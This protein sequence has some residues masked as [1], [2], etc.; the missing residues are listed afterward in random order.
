MGYSCL[1]LIFTIEGCLTEIS[2]KMKHGPKGMDLLNTLWHGC[3]GLMIAEDP[4]IAWGLIF[5]YS[6]ALPCDSDQ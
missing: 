5:V 4:W 6:A 1:L 2:I 3:S